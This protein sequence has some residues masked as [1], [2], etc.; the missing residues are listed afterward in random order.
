MGISFPPW[1]HRRW[2]ELVANARRNARRLVTSF[3]IHKTAQHLLYLQ[4]SDATTKPWSNP[5]D[6]PDAPKAYSM[7]TDIPI[8]RNCKDAFIPDSFC[9]CQGTL[10]VIDPK[11]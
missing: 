10:E 6:A 1:F 7:L 11:S 2:P 3:D 9:S 8:D 4:T 5:A